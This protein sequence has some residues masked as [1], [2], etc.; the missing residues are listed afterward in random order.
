MSEEHANGARRNEPPWTR[1]L[2]VTTR[3]AVGTVLA[4]GDHA[5]AVVRTATERAEAAAGDSSTSTEPGREVVVRTTDL[6]EVADEAAAGGRPLRTMLIGALFAAEDRVVDLTVAVARA[7]PLV[8][9]PWNM[10]LMRPIRA[11]VDAVLEDLAER[12]AGEEKLA[13]ATAGH[14]FDATIETVTAS[15]VID[16]TVNE[17]V[18]R[19]IDPVLQMAVPK[20]LADLQ[21]QPEALVP[22]VQ[23]I[24]SQVL[25]PILDEAL[26]EV[27]DQMKGQP[28]LLVPFIESLV[29]EIIDPVLQMALPKAIE[30]LNEDPTVVRDLVRDQSTGIAGELA[31]TVRTRAVT[32]DDRIDRIASRILRRRPPALEPTAEPL[33]ALPPGPA[34]G[35]ER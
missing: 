28:E 33:D 20:A 25:Q 30:Y 16:E 18:E 4:V 24:V 13:R 26:P 21:G 19:I 5:A 35:A 29:N 9:R 15:P 11:R 27:I 34:D 14:A 32:V 6:A 1:S 22:L 31:G 17:I 3:F 7:T 8:S 2:R 10:A 23:S 12:G